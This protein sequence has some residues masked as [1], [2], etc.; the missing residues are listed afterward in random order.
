MGD[1]QREE[2]SSTRARV[3]CAC[4]VSDAGF[5]PSRGIEYKKAPVY[6]IDDQEP[7]EEQ[8][9]HSAMARRVEI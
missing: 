6:D 8:N 9:V 4:G 7:V 5:S 1:E 2:E 3:P